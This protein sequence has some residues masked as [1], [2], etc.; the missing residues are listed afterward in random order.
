MFVYNIKLL[1]NSVSSVQFYL[2]ES[3]SIGIPT[4][5]F[6]NSY[7]EILWIW[8]RLSAI[9]E[10]SNLYTTMHAHY[11]AIQVIITE[12]AYYLGDNCNII[13]FLI[14]FRIVKGAS[15]NVSYI[16]IGEFPNSIPFLFF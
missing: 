1:N 8:I 13:G 2:F 4:W 9:R 15:Y 12:D 10:N 7:S 11:A 6:W 3:V 5:W 16:L 14:W